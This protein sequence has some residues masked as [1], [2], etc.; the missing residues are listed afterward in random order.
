MSV[1]NLFFTVFLGILIFIIYFHVSN[2]V[3]DFYQRKKDKKYSSE[4]TLRVLIFITPAFIVLFIFILY[5][6]FETVR[7]SF[8]D[9]FGRE[10]VGLYNYRWAINDPEFKRS[11]LNNLGWLLIVPTLSTF[12][13]LVIANLADRIW[14]GSIAKS[15]IFMPMAISFVGAGVIWKFIY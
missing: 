4:N 11:I 8:Y 12:F 2:S 5:P 14:W 1:L 9:K 13:G 7:L 15:I 10:F 6:V 3:L